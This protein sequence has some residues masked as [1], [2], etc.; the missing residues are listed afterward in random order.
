M[1]D[2]LR[3]EGSPIPGLLVV[4][5]PVRGDN[6]GWFKES[7]QREKMTALGLPD[8][9]PVQSNVSFNAKAGATRGIHAEPWDK[10]VSLG[11]GRMFGAWVDLR[12]GDSFGRVF[13]LEMGPETAVFVPRGVGNAYQTLEDATA[14]TYLVNDHWSPEARSSY[15]FVNLGD[16]DLA[17]P[18]PIPLSEAELSQA[19]REHPRLSEVRPFERLRTLV[20]GSGGQVGKALTDLL[21]AADALDRSRLDLADPAAYSSVRWGD[22]DTIVNAAA[23][24]AVDAAESPEG[25]RAAWEINVAAAGRLVEEARRHRATFVHLSSDYVFD[26]TREVHPET[27]AFSPLGVYGQTKAAGDAVVA[28]YPRHYIV[29][30]S[31]VIGSGHNFV[32]TMAGLADRGVSPSVIDDQVGRLTFAEDLARAIDHLLAS[33]APYGTYNVSCNGDPM[34]WADIAQ[35]VFEARGRAGS[36]VTR[37]STEEYAAG[38][39][40]AP[41]PRNSV[42]DLRK[43]EATGFEPGDAD[44][45][46]AG[47]LKQL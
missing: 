6:R 38:R 24:T 39:A 7:W 15:T 34:S 45:R 19:D 36:D 31:W 3:V 44:E 35:R 23:Y 29:R 22:Y 32:R 26:G 27:E 30:T 4:H 8:F 10:F 28:T 37:V 17:V 9:E 20:V 5:L 11:T 16:P 2:E 41:R 13:T 40:T 47:Y 43:I 33:R 21:P 1:S 46:L 18:W 12:R 14:Y 42:L 25:R